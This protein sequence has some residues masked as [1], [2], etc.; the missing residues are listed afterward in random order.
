MRI[1][2]GGLALACAVVLLSGACGGD[3]E[4]SID[5]GK[6]EERPIP[7]GRVMKFSIIRG[8]STSSGLTLSSSTK[9]IA[10]KARM[11]RRSETIFAG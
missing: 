9:W 10:Q 8:K 11:W 1:W 3:Q 5:I 4:E 6:V 7:S 2:I